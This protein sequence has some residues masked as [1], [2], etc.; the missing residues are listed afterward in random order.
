MR[1]LISCLVVSENRI[2]KEEVTQEVTRA[3]A[4]GDGSTYL[5][6]C[7]NGRALSVAMLVVVW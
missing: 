2:G 1:A 3:K 5:S 7:A 4:A 6:C